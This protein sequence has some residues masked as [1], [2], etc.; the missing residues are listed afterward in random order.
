MPH[1]KRL[2]LNKPTD[3][4]AKLD[5]RLSNLLSP[6]TMRRSLPTGGFNCAVTAWSIT[7]W[8]WKVLSTDTRESFAQKAR[9]RIPVM[10]SVLL[11]G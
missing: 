9:A 1:R 2:G 3:L 7:D 6:W 8:V 10:S 11:R 4:L 5:W